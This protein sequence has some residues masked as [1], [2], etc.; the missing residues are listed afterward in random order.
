VPSALPKPHFS[1][2]RELR[3]DRT[4]TSQPLGRAENEKEDGRISKIGT[5]AED[6]GTEKAPDE[7]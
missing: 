3:A 4:L 2:P 7:E 6:P 1:R 5:S